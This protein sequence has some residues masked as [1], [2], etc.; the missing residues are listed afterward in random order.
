MHP[1]ASSAKDTPHTP[2]V[3]TNTP[4]AKDHG[5]DVPGADESEESLT[6]KCGEGGI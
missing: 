2:Q 5:E 3:S 6:V 1:S 4:S